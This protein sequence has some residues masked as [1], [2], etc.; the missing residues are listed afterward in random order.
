MYWSPQA[1]TFK[2]SHDQTT[3]AATRVP[4]NADTQETNCQALM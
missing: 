4:G 3:A 1:L 2:L